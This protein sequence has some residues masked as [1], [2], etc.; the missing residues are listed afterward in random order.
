MLADIGH[1]SLDAAFQDNPMQMLERLKRQVKQHL[2]PTQNR[3][4]FRTGEFK[5]EENS[6]S[7]GLS[8]RMQ[9]NKPRFVETRH[10]TGRSSAARER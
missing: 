5:G 6:K 1:R 9:A 2:G 4:I 7:D 8:G 3:R 10:R